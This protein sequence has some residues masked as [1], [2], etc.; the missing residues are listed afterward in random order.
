MKV[1]EIP[2]T[3]QYLNNEPNMLWMKQKEPT[4]G[5]VF[6]P[7]LFSKILGLRLEDFSTKFPVQVVSTGVP[8]FVVP[9]KSL[10]SLRSCKIDRDTYFKLV[11]NQR[12]KSILVFSPEAYSKDGNLSVRVFTEYYGIP[13]DAATGSGNGCLAGYLSKYRYFGSKE[14]EVKV[15]QGY[16]IGRPSRLFLKAKSENEFAVMVGGR[17]FEVAEGTINV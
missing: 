1:G 3:I 5:K 6:D 10:E 9:L 8:F 13:E 12:A 17:V 14:I 15:Q 16:E 2:V 7:K 4:F 11:R